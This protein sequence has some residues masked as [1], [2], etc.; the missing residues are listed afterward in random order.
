MK[1]EMT[2]PCDLCPFR[3][4]DRRLHVD[5][6]RLRE[7]ARGEFV[8]HKTAEYAEDEEGGGGGYVDNGRTSQHCAGALIFHEHME[9]PHM[10][11]LIYRRAG[12]YRPDRLDMNAPVFRSWREV[13]AAEGREDEVG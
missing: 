7:F 6:D 8:C 12:L 4:D 9:A 13:Y 1:Y 2:K 5:P 3:N 11:M 10:W